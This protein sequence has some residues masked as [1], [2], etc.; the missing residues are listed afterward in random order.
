MIM[1]ADVSHPPQRGGPIPPSIAV[2]IAATSGDNVR[3]LPS[4]RLQEGDDLLW[5]SF[6]V[7]TELSQLAIG[8]VGQLGNDFARLSAGRRF[9]PRSR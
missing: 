1:G 9:R 4:M 6:R 3:W 2:T 7:L 5:Q 8:H